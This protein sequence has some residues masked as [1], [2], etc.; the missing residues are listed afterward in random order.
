M[1]G[2]LHR[3]QRPQPVFASQDVEPLRHAALRERGDGE[4]AFDGG[5]LAGAAGAVGDDLKAAGPAGPW[6]SRRGGGRGWFPR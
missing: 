3:V 5:D 1:D 4:A 6:P 2:D